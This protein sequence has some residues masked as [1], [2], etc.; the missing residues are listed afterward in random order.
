[1]LQFFLLWLW[2]TGTKDWYNVVNNQLA[3]SFKNKNS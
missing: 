3:N 1:M 2:R